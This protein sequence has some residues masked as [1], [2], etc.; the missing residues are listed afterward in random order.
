MGLHDNL[1]D[2]ESHRSDGYVRMLNGIFGT[3]KVLWVRGFEEVDF[4]LSHI[5][6]HY[7]FARP[8]T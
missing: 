1:Q 6:F 7:R 3:L 2:Y 5:S 4:G 8:D